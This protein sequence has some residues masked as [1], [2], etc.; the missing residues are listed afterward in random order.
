[1][2]VRPGDADALVVGTAPADPVAAVLLLHGGREDGDAP[3]PALNLPGARMR[4]FGRAVLRAARPHPVLLGAV[5]YRHRGWNGAR[6]DAAHDARRALD[7]LERLAGPVPVVL[8][9][10][11]MGGRAALR[12]ADHPRVRGVVALAPWCPRGEPVAHLAGRRVYVLH[13]E[14]DRVTGA[15]DSW[16]FVRRAQDAG[17]E[18]RGIAMPR[19]GHAMLRD[20]GTWH[21]LTAALVTGMLGLTPSPP[22]LAAPPGEAGLVHPAHHVLTDLPDTS[23]TG[24]TG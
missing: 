24:T 16:D 23:P 14:A 12:V 17:A 22:G 21:R 5:R 2:A 19:G 6:D 8:V 4:P 18:A 20:A 7:A 3:P 13:D 15:R 9:G 1:M 11:S 10:H